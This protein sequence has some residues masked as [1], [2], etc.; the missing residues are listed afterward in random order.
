MQTRSR[1]SYVLACVAGL[2]MLGA[3]PEL[4]AAKGLPWNI[5]I[6]SGADADGGWI[7][8][9]VTVSLQGRPVQIPAVLTVGGGATAQQKCQALAQALDGSRHLAATCTGTRVRVELEDT[10]PFEAIVS[11][12]TTESNTGERLTGIR[13]DPAQD[14]VLMTNVFLDIR[15]TSTGTGDAVLQIGSGPLAA[16]RTDRRTE[17]EIGRDLAAAFNEAYSGTAYRAEAAGGLVTVRNVPCPEGVT[18]GS[19]DSSL[20]F[21]LGM[22]LV[23]GA[24]G[25]AP[26]AT[27]P[28]K[29]PALL[30]VLFAAAGFVLGTALVWLLRPKRA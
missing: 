25:G 15:G 11:I 22:A 14:G 21:A 17:A 9:V 6:G 5:D 23:E 24:A 2:A 12:T 18:G 1:W 30:F 3:T 29:R 27:P 26:P 19:S 10:S 16:V 28:A 20:E 13:D 4:A 8:V 7:S